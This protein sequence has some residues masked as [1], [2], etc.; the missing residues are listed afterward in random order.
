VPPVLLFFLCA[1]NFFSF[2]H[3]L[4]RISVPSPERP[5]PVDGGVPVPPAGLAARVERGGGV[6]RG[7]GLEARRQG[8]HVLDLRI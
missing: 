4:F 7:V 6:G 3:L 1:L 2:S 5:Q 8:V